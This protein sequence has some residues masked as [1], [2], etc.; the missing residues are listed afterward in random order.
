MTPHVVGDEQDRHRQALAEVVDEV[1]DLGLDGHIEGG[2]RLVGDQELG[3]TG[4]RHRDHH[5]LAQTTGEF[6]GV[7]VEALGGSG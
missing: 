2:G 7:L 3:L 5:P 1:E 6:V 4:Q